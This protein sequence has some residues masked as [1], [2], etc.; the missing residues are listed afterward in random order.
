MNRVLIPAEY[1]LGQ[2][3]LELEAPWLTPEAIGTLEHFVKPN[4]RVLEFGCG[5]STLFFARRAAS[6]LSIESA[7]TYSQ[8]WVEKVTAVAEQRGIKNITIRQAAT[9]QDMIRV[10]YGARFNIALIDCVEIDRRDALAY[11]QSVVDPGG[12]IVIDNYSAPYCAGIDL[13]LEGKTC[14]DFDDSHWV[15][16][17]TRVVYV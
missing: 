11:A 15:G 14:V 9:I 12:M 3:L 5:G 1:W 13:L 10:V 8:G 4:H 17:G 6:V 7:C 2:G 16:N